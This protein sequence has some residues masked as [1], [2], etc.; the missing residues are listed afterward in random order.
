MTTTHET[1][2]WTAGDDWQINATLLDETGTPFNLRRIASHQ[3][4]ADGQC[5][6]ARAR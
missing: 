1:V 3:M 4:G 6:P 2:N 5:L